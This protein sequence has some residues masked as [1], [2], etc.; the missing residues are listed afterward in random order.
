VRQVADG[1]AVRLVVGLAEWWIFTGG[2][3][4]SEKYQGI[5]QPKFGTLPA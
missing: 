3:L 2:T 5:Q 1:R 4:A